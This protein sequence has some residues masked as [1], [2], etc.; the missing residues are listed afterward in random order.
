[1]ETLLFIVL[2]IAVLVQYGQHLLARLQGAV[3]VVGAGGE[4]A[5]AFARREA[6]R[7]RNAVIGLA[8]ITAVLF[9]TSAGLILWGVYRNEYGLLVKAGAAQQ[10]LDQ[11]G[12]GLIE[13]FGQSFGTTGWLLFG[14]FV[15]LQVVRV[16]VRP[17]PERRPRDTD[18]QW[19]GRVIWHWV[20]PF[21]PIVA[22][23]VVLIYG[24]S[25]LDFMKKVAE[26]NHSYLLASVAV[27][28][29]SLVFGSWL[30]MLSRMGVA[31]A[32][33]VGLALDFVGA[34]LWKSADVVMDLLS[35]FGLAEKLGPRASAR[36]RLMAFAES[37]SWPPVMFWFLGT[38]VLM[39][40]PRKSVVLG[41]FPA[42]VFGILLYAFIKWLGRKEWFILAAYF[43]TL[44]V[45]V[46][47]WFIQVRFP[48]VAK[49]VGA[50]MDEGELMAP[51]LFPHGSRNE[52]CIKGKLSWAD[53]EIRKLGDMPDLPMPG[54]PAPA[55]RSTDA[56]SE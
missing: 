55:G 17:L 35:K 19:V 50:W 53:D 18:P 48:T 3:A 23:L 46:P 28:A 20:G 33:G 34:V 24:R 27:A 43:A 2:V 10:E 42:A 14:L 39:V 16:L 40:W 56:P 5:A 47:A 4:Y 36:E 11:F 15:V 7:V 44:F 37:M 21:V 12:I 49:A 13:K 26:E 45:F 38:T 41:M 8:A 1:M 54:G 30:V 22:V 6:P 9:A 51:C 29:G 31:V 25:F 52:E 32:W